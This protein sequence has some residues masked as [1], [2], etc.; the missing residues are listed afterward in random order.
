MSLVTEILLRITFCV[1]LF[2]LQIVIPLLALL[3]SPRDAGTHNMSAWTSKMLG[4]RI[5]KAGQNTCYVPEEKS[6]RVMYL[7][8]HRS[9]GDFI[10]D[11]LLTGFRGGSLSRI[12]VIVGIP[13][14]ATLAWLGS[15]QRGTSALW[16]FKRAKGAT[17][18]LWATLDR[19]FE[20]AIEKAVVVYPEG[21]RNRSDKPLPIRTGTLRYAFDRNVH[22]QVMVAEGKER[23]INEAQLVTRRSPNVVTVSYSDPIVPKNYSTFEG[24]HGAVCEAWRTT[25]LAAYGAA[26]EAGY[27]AP[28]PALGPDG[29]AESATAADHKRIHRPPAA[30]P[31]TP[32]NPGPPPNQHASLGMHMARLCIVG[33]I[34]AAAYYT[35]YE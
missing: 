15:G 1:D 14:P 31:W 24:F 34:S 35:L 8:N 28:P 22:V 33:A 12:M 18:A 23:V 29:T 20:V 5:H 9:W 11:R 30:V 21:H 26:A 13:M 19:N 32:P 3:Y 25:W 6:T 7:A 2:L 4:Y 10:V 17:P 27:C 16:F